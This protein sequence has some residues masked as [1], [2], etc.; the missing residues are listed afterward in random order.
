MTLSTVEEIE[1]AIDALTAEEWRQLEGWLDR[2]ERAE[3][4]D[5]RIRTDLGAGRLDRA[6]GQ[7]LDDEEHGRVRPL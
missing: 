3:T 7:A 5:N 4:L 6:I 2:Y 1:R